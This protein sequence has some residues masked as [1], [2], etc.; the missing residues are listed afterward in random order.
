MATHNLTPSD[1]LSS[2]GLFGSD[3]TQMPIYATHIPDTAAMKIL[4][5]WVKSYRTLVRIP[6]RDSVVNV[7]GRMTR[8]PAET[9]RIQNR[10]LIVPASW[11]G[12]AQMMNVGGRVYALS[13]VGKGR[14]A[15]PQSAPSGLYFFKVGTRTFR[16]FISGN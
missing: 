11:T 4:G 12:K 2:A 5:E 1:V 14:Y 6:D 10:Q 8:Y 9:A 15:I 7:N 13:S 3:G 16:T